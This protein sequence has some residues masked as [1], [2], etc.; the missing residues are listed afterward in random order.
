[1]EGP[2]IIQGTYQIIKEIG[3]GSGGTVFLAYHNR[4]QKNVVL[5]KMKVSASKLLD[6]RAETDILKNLHH[7]YLPQ[8]FDFVQSMDEYGAETIYTVMDFIP[9]KSF[10][11]LLKEGYTFTPTQVAKYLKQLSEAAEYLH[12]QKP[13]ILHGDIK[14]ANV[15]LTP[16][17]NICLI[18]FNIS[19]FTDN[20]EILA[21]TKGYASPE[22]CQAVQENRKRRRQQREQ[23][24]AMAGASFPAPGNKAADGDATSIDDDAAMPDGDATS[25]DDDAT[26]LDSD[27]DPAGGGDVL[28]KRDS[29]A[30]FS[31]V[32]RIDQRSDVFSIGATAYCL[33]TGRKPDADYRRQV[34]IAQMDLPVSE[35]LAF[36]ID[37]A[38][39]IDPKER[40]QSVSE[41]IRALN[42][43]GKKDRRYKSLLI[44]EVLFCLFFIIC[45]AVS[46]VVSYSGYRMMKTEESSAYYETALSLYEQKSYDEDLKYI[47]QEALA[48]ESIYDRG[49][50]GNLYYLAADCSFELEEYEAAA[51]FY[52]QA[53]IYNSFNIEYYCNYAI[54]LARL[55]KTEEASGVIDTAV[56]KGLSADRISL[57]SGEL[58]ARLGNLDEA[59]KNYRSCIEKTKDSYTLARAYI[60][61]SDLYVNAEGYES[62]TSLVQKNIDILAEAV[63]KTDNSYQ[64]VILERLIQAD[65]EMAELSGDDAYIRDAIAASQQLLDLGWETFT[66]DMNLA[67]LYDKLGEY[68]NSRAVYEQIL[69]RFGDDYR[70]YKNLAF[71]ELEIQADVDINDRDYGMFKDYYE[72]AVALFEQSGEQKD[73][74]TGMQLLEESFRSVRNGGWIP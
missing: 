59:E 11:D 30:G 61:C 17:D 18:D 47:L 73:S 49:T 70:V 19:G 62:Q 64:P 1:M 35:G 56:Q 36:V 52:R 9:G 72:K 6:S 53:L 27:G 42:S 32:V 28:A 41:M 39:K 44:K 45:G 22:Q 37:K 71:L 66:N 48:D 15:M 12:A 10:E 51:S 34:P 16:E 57:M 43:L 4:L 54:A 38:M 3:S 68:D 5:K 65:S 50:L 63:S 8:V 67:L 21:F 58:A 24:A 60:M 13:P 7:P 2:Q 69:K 14:P 23:D 20:L 25:I 29:Y 55:G 74:D 31:Q 40:F 46:A 26:V 33:L